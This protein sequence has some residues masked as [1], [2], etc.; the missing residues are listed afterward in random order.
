MGDRAIEPDRD[1]TG[2][3]R[4]LGIGPAV[5][6]KVRAVLRIAKSAVAAS[7]A[8]DV[9]IGGHPVAGRKPADVLADRHDL[10]AQVDAEYRRQLDAVCRMRVS[11]ANPQVAMVHGCGVDADE[12]IVWTWLWLGSL[13]QSQ[14]L[15]SAVGV[16]PH[17]SH[18]FD[19]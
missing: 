17:R 14:L 9:R 3:D 4:V 2:H 11:P 15:R 13:L 19:T 5:D 16:N 12:Q 7:S 8:G 1:R 18:R 6:V 10:A